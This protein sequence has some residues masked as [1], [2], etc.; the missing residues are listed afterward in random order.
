MNKQNLI[1]TKTTT[2]AGAEKL[3]LMSKNA[4]VYTDFLKFQGRVFKH[5]TSVALEFFARRPNAMFIATS[6]QWRSIGCSAIQGEQ[7]VQFMGKDGNI[8]EYY[9]FSQ[10]AEDNPPKVWT[11]NAQTAKVLKSEL[12]IADNVSL[13][14]GLLKSTVNIDDIKNCM[15]RLGIPPKDFKGFRDDFLSAV[16][17]V[18]AG[19]M[20]VGGN[21]FN[22]KASNEIFKNLSA[23]QKMFFLN[24]VS[25]VARKALMKAENAMNVSMVTKEINERN[26]QNDLSRMGTAYTRTAGESGG[27]TA[28]RSTERDVTEQDNPLQ[29][30]TQGGNTGLGVDSDNTQWEQ[31][32]MVS[33]IQANAGRGNRPDGNVQIQP[34]NGDVFNGR[35]VGAVNGGTTDRQ[36]WQS[37]D[38]LHG[39]EL[40]RGSGVHEA[41]TH[42]SDDSTFGGQVGTRVQGVVGGTVRTMD[43]QTDNG[44]LRGRREMVSND[45]FLRRWNGNEG[46]S[47]NQ[48]NQTITNLDNRIDGA[49]EENK[50]STETT[51]DVFV[52]SDYAKQIK[53]S[54]QKATKFIENGDYL[55]AKTVLEQLEELSNKYA[56]LEEK[57]KAEEITEQ[58]VQ[59]LRNIRPARKSIQNLLEEEVAQTAK[60]E[61]L[62]NTQM[63]E[64]SAYEMRKSNNAW[65]EDNS[66]TVPIIKVEKNN[67]PDKLYDVRKD[68]NIKRG[69][70]TNVDTGLEIIFSKR[71]IEEVVAKAVQDD[72]R[73][74][75]TTARISMLYQVQDLIENS[76]CFDSQV[77]EYNEKTSKNK[78]PNT[79]LMHQMYGVVKYNADYYLARLS[80][81]ESYFTNKNND[82]K[83]TSNRLYN[84]K[85]I[86]V[87]P[88]EANRIFSPAVDNENI[89]KDTSISVTTISIPQLYEFVKTFD[90]NFYEN[91]NSPG[92]LERV[93][94]QT[95][96]N[97]FEEN[98][99]VFENQNNIETEQENLVEIGLTNG[100]FEEK[101]FLAVLNEFGEQDDHYL[102][103]NGNMPTFSTVSS[104]QA[105]AVKNNLK[106]VYNENYKAWK[107][108]DKQQAVDF[109]KKEVTDQLLNLEDIQT[110]NNSLEDF[111]NL[112]FRSEIDRVLGEMLNSHKYDIT[113][114]EINAEIVHLINDKDFSNKVFDN[115][116]EV[117]NA[118]QN[119]VSTKEAEAKP[120]ENENNQQNQD[121]VQTEEEY[122]QSF[123]KT[124][125][126]E[127]QTQDEQ[128]AQT[129]GYK[130]MIVHI[131]GKFIG[132]YKSEGKYIIKNSNLHG[133]YA[134]CKVNE[135]GEKIGY[136]KDE[137]GNTP[138]F[139]TMNE[140]MNYLHSTDDLFFEIYRENGRVILPSDIYREWWEEDDREIAQAQKEPTYKLKIFRT[141][142]KLIGKH[143]AER[144]YVIDSINSNGKYELGKVNDYGETLG[145]YQDENGNSPTF[146]TFQEAYKYLI[147]NNFVPNHLF[148]DFYDEIGVPISL[149]KMYD[150][151]GNKISLDELQKKYYNTFDIY[152]EW[153]TDDNRKIAEAKQTE[154]PVQVEEPAQEVEQQKF[155]QML[156]E[157]RQGKIAEITEKSVDTSYISD[158]RKPN[159][160]NIKLKYDDDSGFHITADTN[161]IKNGIISVFGQNQQAVKDYIEKYADD[162]NLTDEQPVQ[163]EESQTELAEQPAQTDTEVDKQVSKTEQP[164]QQEKKQKQRK[165]LS[166][167]LYDKFVEMFPNMANKSHRYENYK[168]NGGFEPLSIEHLGANTYGLMT[169]YTQN[170]D[171]MRDPDF[172]FEIDHQNKTLTVL[173]YQQDGVPN[174]GTVYQRVFDEDGNA[175]KKLLSAL[176][177]NFMQNL[178]NIEQSDRKLAEYT[179]KNGNEIVVEKTEEIDQTEKE[180]T[181][182]YPELRE[183]L[184]SFS[185][186]YNLGELHI[187]P[188]ANSTWDTWDIKETFADGYT[189]LM[190][191]INGEYDKPFTPQTLQVALENFEQTQKD[192]GRDIGNLYGREQIIE[193]HGG[194][195]ELPKPAENLPE[196]VYASSPT[197]KVSDNINAIRELLRIENVI[198]NGE[199]PYSENRNSY[200]SKE[201]SDAKLRRYCGWGGLPQVF[202][203]NFTRFNYAREQLKN[204]LTPAE[205]DSARASVLN[206]HYT[207]Q[208][209]IDAMYKALSNMELP[210]NSRILEPA[211]GT[212]NYIQRLPNAYA[213]SEVVGVELDSITARIAG[214][215]NSDNPNINIIN[216]GFEYTDLQNNSFDLAIGNVPFGD[217]KLD[218]PDYTQYWLIHDAFFRK[219]L[220]KVAPGGVVAFVTFSGTMDK[221]N[222]KVR[223]YLATNA[224]LIGAIRLPNNAFSDA[225][226]KV[227]SDIIFLQKRAEPLQAFEPKPDWCYTVPNKEGLVINKYFVDNPQMILGKMAKTTHFD[228]LTCEPFA[229]KD[230]K[231]QLDFAVGRLNAKIVIE[232]REKQLDERTGKIE[233]WGKNFSFHV[234]DDKVY[235]RE[236]GKM[237]EITEKKQGETLKDFCKLRDATRELLELQKTNISDEDL[238]PKRE[239]LNKLFDEFTKNHGH[240]PLLGAGGGKLKV[241]N[242]LENDSDYAIVKGLEN[243]EKGQNNQMEYKKAEILS[244]RTVNPIAEVTS[245]ENIEQALQ[246]SLD[247]KGRIDMPYMASLL[248]DKYQ[249]LQ[250]VDYPYLTISAIAEKICDE[251]V[252][253]ERIFIDPEKEVVGYPFSGVVEKEEYLSGN[254]RKK[255]QMAKEMAKTNPDF[256]R[257]VTA[258]EKVIP[259]DIKAEEIDASMGVPWVDEKDYTEFLAYLSGRGNSNARNCEV[260]YSAETGNFEVINAGSKKNLNLNETTTYG[261]ADYSL[262]ALAEKILNQK[263][264]SV[265]VKVPHPT[266]PGKIITQTDSKRT[267]IALEKAKKIKEEF[268]KWIFAD[269]GRKAKYEQRYNNIFNSLVGREYDGSNLT[270]DGLNNNFELRPHQKNCVARAI[271]GGNTLAAHVVGAGKS[272]VIIASV[273]KKK[274]LGLINKACVVVPKALIEQTANEWR[275]LYPNAKVLTVTKKDLDS[276]ENRDLF[277]A[278]VATGSYDAVV[279]SQEQFTKMPMSKEYQQKYIENQLYEL[280]DVL[281]ER[282]IQSTG[283]KDF[284]VKVLEN[285]KKKLLNRLKGFI[286]PKTANAKK[287]DL[288]DFEALGF[289]YLVCDEAHSYKN[290]FIS[291][292]MTS[293][294]G[295]N[296]NASGKAQDMQM[297]TDYFNQT[298]GQGHI[299]FAT[300]TPVSNS[301]TE[302]YVMTRY[303]R[304]DLLAQAGVSRFDDWAATFGNVVTKNMQSADG[305]LKLQSCFAQF[306]NLPELMAMYKEFADIQSAEKLDLPKP[307][308]K[309]GKPQ[310][311]KVKASPE[312]REYV[313]ELATRSQEISNATVTP[314]EDNMLKI[315]GEARIIGLGNLAVKSLYQKRQEEL[316]I[317]FDQTQDGKVDACVEKVAEIYKQTE[318]TK[319]VQIIFSDIAVNSDNGNFSA[320]DYIK[321]KLVSDYNIPENEIIFAPKSD[322]KDKQDIFQKINESEYRIVIASTGTLGTGANIQ[323]NLYALHHL[324]IPWKPS[325]FEQREGRILRQ[326]N[327]NKEVEILNYITE[328]TLDSYLYQTVTDKARFIAQLLDNKAPARVMEDCDEKVLTFGEI[329]AAAE[330]NPDFKKRI[331]LSNEIAELQ[332]LKSEYA[333]ETALTAKRIENIPKQIEYS[334]QLL[335]KISHDQK[336]AEIQLQN[337]DEKL[338]L[339]NIKGNVIYDKKIINEI[340]T[341]MAVSKLENPNGKEK[342]LNLNGFEVSAEVLKVGEFE[343]VS[344]KI[345]GEVEYTCS[346]NIDEKANN[347][348]R[349]ENFFEKAIA[350]RFNEVKTE[351]TNLKENLKQAKQQ[352]EKPFEHEQ[353]LEEK[354]A[355]FNKLEKKLMSVTQQEDDIVDAEEFVETL[356]E[357][358]KREEIYNTDEGDYQVVPD[359]DLPKTPALTR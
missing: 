319:G 159:F 108:S 291:T 151:N 280:E 243:L 329:Q 348:K 254:V 152:N 258:L 287:D 194:K 250:N 70:F 47:A 77:S 55:Q 331:E 166:N 192:Y 37:V 312:Q 294:K 39:G 283:K 7:S 96:Q 247:R 72:K 338:K 325:D 57:I 216:G 142:G 276:K 93:I 251:L 78:S 255:L 91:L 346:A 141:D 42:I 203:E 44:D 240:L 253:Q 155:T 154:E 140:A 204:L 201:N 336:Q 347:Y 323:Q 13:V 222:P 32:R 313:H 18:I 335:D 273:M 105:F 135:N 208:I 22:I 53:Q 245:V 186:K 95:Q 238:M 171:L 138:T 337:P 344:F 237:T 267:R 232:K 117:Y 334:E 227:T 27:Y 304:P 30:P 136:Y 50:T 43:T 127:E 16:Q 86:K 354:I 21:R 73:N 234:K 314:E 350:N 292:K 231:E 358:S 189:H 275:K 268:Q 143:N 176:E 293:V 303:L 185:E 63:G 252:Q 148:S 5:G 125:Q 104:A 217:Y 98:K 330:G 122:Q 40:S 349:L 187:S 158:A 87:T 6:Q 181:E 295:V 11:V 289:D 110:S 343:N 28:P 298:M 180:I 322:A 170:G 249:D 54:K 168:S 342:S 310:I 230:L 17:V 123:E 262:Y 114:T 126:A 278:K 256:E 213:G 23:Q 115:A 260:K 80:I 164:I 65:R 81:E 305:Q 264:I 12:G 139:A 106:L 191:V 340:L 195:S 116:G 226:T 111:S 60:F 315:T 84:L 259:E 229:D 281:R 353:E 205:Y 239:N 218:D 200:N 215:L 324:D 150:E 82:F 221:K 242:L 89:T 321:D 35:G 121:L 257:N 4:D 302:L 113:N 196:I 212:G 9:D 69:T 59:A 3:D 173:E 145:F 119:K 193:N 167:K 26:E 288:L 296:T 284:S 25:A 31:N 107:E 2:T 179:D 67:I 101:Y 157:I 102:D 202:D 134:L 153:D 74:I 38:G 34:D 183:T 345:K 130:P 46:E 220:D 56:E 297:K 137:N 356:E 172:T 248:V 207:P 299:L 228:M 100:S 36:V 79:L 317:D 285:A 48:E 165:T 261:T 269:E 71:T 333:H 277:T 51:A 94:E 146:D 58:D 211:C 246:T 132:K 274:Q 309:G 214:A 197:Q 316:P 10:M 241:Q 76:V 235:Y 19:R 103:E 225:G 85:D 15:K 351:I 286:N 133:K 307:K 88:I 311:V 144:H 355:E 109:I 175:D 120:I 190:G 290:G 282:K 75:P 99:E 328:G 68:N 327:K 49:F 301:M 174:I 178:E 210:Q 198:K 162:V 156:S 199:N 279:V 263:R 223:E 244:K 318:E 206:A 33:D 352:I 161:K 326:G 8:I 339:T 52:L 66:K 24:Y 188:N 270:F 29:M 169:F 92:R 124:E 306:K 20:E 129:E 300:G 131:D 265:S 271:Y 320:Y 128:P 236:N 83:G 149:N 112:T 357:N 62:L 332:L 41:S 177:K 90:Q 209:I 118:I 1:E 184:N 233:P 219:A 97:Q 61:K 266:D 308:L 224:N 160:S 147:D 45:G 341:G 14:N 64:K 163:A 359:D 272:A 182:P